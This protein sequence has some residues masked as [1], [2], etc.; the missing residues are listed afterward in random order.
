MKFAAL[1]SGGKDSILGAILSIKGGNELVAIANLYPR[2]DA[3]EIDSYMYQT[4][5]HRLINSVGEAIG[6]PLYK[7]KIRGEM[8]LSTLD[9]SFKEGDEVEDLFELVKKIK[10][11]IPDLAAISTGAV[12]SKYQ[13]S[14]V[15]N[16][17]ERLNL[18]H[19]KF[20]WRMEPSKL[21]LSLKENNVEAIIVKTA[22]S[23]LNPNEFLGVDVVQ[24]IPKLD[25]I[26]FNLIYRN[27]K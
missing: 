22:S 10:F 7:R 17:C 6:V 12:F 18:K 27:R 8:I 15:D 20:L 23:D 25:L 11:D 9:Y 13:A 24:N 4:V 1:L 21:L 2:E 14:R 16:I 26:V 5:G 19:L 3:D